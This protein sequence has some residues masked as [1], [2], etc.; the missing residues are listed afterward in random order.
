[1]NL[2]NIRLAE[3]V[4]NLLVHAG[5]PEAIVAGGFLRDSLLDI[6][7]KDID[8]FIGNKAAITKEVLV[9]ALA[10]ALGGFARVEFDVTY[11]AMEVDRII[12][13]SSPAFPFPIQVIEM[14]PGLAPVEHARKH[15]FGICQ[16]WVGSHGLDS[17]RAFVLDHSGKTCTLVHCEN[18]DEHARSM[19]R[20]ERLK[21]KL[22]GFRLVDET[23]WASQ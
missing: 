21:D 6:E 17:T 13:V 22:E 4:R 16:V 5:F 23:P 11:S 3:Q 19:R 18:E 12:D 20:W 14:K 9:S 2:S 15:D 1:M 10:E 8:V 7:P